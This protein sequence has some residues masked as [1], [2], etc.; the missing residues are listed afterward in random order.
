[1]RGIVAGLLAGALA[2]AS[3]GCS[4]SAAHEPERLTVFAAASLHDVL[5]ELAPE[6][7]AQHGVDVVLSFAG[8]S[9]L[10]AQLE[11]GAAADVLITAD[12]RTMNQAREAEVATGQP[13]MLASNHLVLVTPADNPA[14]VTGLDDSLTGSAFVVCAPQVPCGA[15]S[16]RLAALNNLELKPVS[17]EPSVTAVL[18]KVTSGQADAGLVYT[19][20][21]A[22]SADAVTSIEVP[23]AQ[24]VVNRYPGAVVANSP[25]PEL[26]QDWLNWIAAP[27]GQ[28]ALAHAG[29]GPP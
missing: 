14:R 26:A 28:A 20:D 18:A 24:Q 2:L 22:G 21:A 19:S 25:K 10:V 7:Q 29:F 4:A 27:Q 1:M 15:A 23:H 5:T 9:D 12:E 3:A 17:E 11:A 8:S 6:F 13:I 16:E